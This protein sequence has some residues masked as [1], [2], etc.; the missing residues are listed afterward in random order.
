MK[1]L[2]IIAVLA[3]AGCA[4]AGGWT[5]PGADASATASVYQ[6]CRELADSTVRPEL[7]INQDIL[8]SRGSDWQRAPIG[9]VEAESMREGTR[10]RAAA[11]LDSCMKSKGFEPAR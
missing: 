5:K 7:D 11:I 2:C 9:R 6:D 8:A 10:G 4:G 1:G 3:L